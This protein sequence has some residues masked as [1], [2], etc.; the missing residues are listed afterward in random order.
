MKRYL[1]LLAACL[2]AYWTALSNPFL[3]DDISCIVQNRFIQDIRNLW[4][5]LNPMNFIHAL[6]IEN[7]G[8]PFLVASTLIDHWIW[9]ENPWGYRLD[10]LLLHALNSF[11]IFRVSLKL[12]PDARF[13]WLAALLFA[14]HPIHSEN[15]SVIAFRADILACLFLLLG[16][17]SFLR[18]RESDDLSRSRAWL[19]ACA[20]FFAFSLFSKESGIV[21]PVLLLTYEL[22]YPK[23]DERRTIPWRYFILISVSMLYYFGFREARSTYNL[24]S[25]SA[26]MAS[27]HVAVIALEDKAASFPPSP[28][29]WKGLSSKPV[30]NFMTMSKIFGEYIGLLLVPYPLQVDYSPD[31]ITSL[32]NRGL[33][34]SWLAWLALAVCAYYFRRRN[35]WITFALLWFAVSLAP[36]S[37]LK[38]LYNLKA[39]RYLYIPSVGFCWLFAGLLASWSMKVGNRLANAAC[40]A[41]LVLYASLC[42]A[43]G[44]D[45]ASES[46]LFETALKSQPG[47]PRIH[48]N[49]GTLYHSR[50]MVPEAEA[51]YRKALELNP[52][53]YESL[54]NLGLLSE[55]AKKEADAVR[56]YKEAVALQPRVQVPYNNLA[57]LLAGQGKLQEAIGLYVQS[58]SVSPDQPETRY[59]LSELYDRTGRP[60]EALRELQADVS[61]PSQKMSSLINMGVIYKENGDLEKAEELFK[62][63]AAL[64]PRS[65]DAAYNL[66]TAYDK[67]GKSK[68]AIA[69][70]T[71]AAALAPSG[72]TRADYNL[73]VLYQ[74]A[75]ELK[76]AERSYRRVLEN[77]PKHL[78][79]LNNL[80]G[81][82]EGRGKLEDA[83]ELF[84]KA[85]EVD[86]TKPGIR[87][88]LGNI[89]LKQNRLDE[90]V[91]QYQLA[92]DYSKLYNDPVEYTAP[93][94]TNLGLCYQRLGRAD[95]AVKEWDLARQADPHYAPAIQALNRLKQ[96]R[97]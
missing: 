43:R 33:W 9:K 65:F 39:E 26:I 62:Q 74:Q 14:L 93:I 10:S 63:A 68:E 30:H 81:L 1:L 78:Q 25:P 16:F 35:P 32:K 34:A 19:S 92:L 38:P 3:W 23:P 60:K 90:A 77:D 36:V 80:G 24:E 69:T 2:A 41:I 37:N 94:H 66:A 57:D 76:K 82:L 75:G 48:Y 53:S 11:L 85:A 95:D 96:G 40:A 67:G 71:K 29:P 49:L 84:Q 91:K 87:T 13:A 86:G 4:V 88:N 61:R 52:N 17:M 20:I 12:R 47:N 42:L 27:R 50:G 15:I 7:S 18:Y 79:A 58:L 31:L 22:L 70:F 45:W 83:W 6:P 28:P 54:T 46:A 97:Q 21:L 89:L 8:R 51:H 64:D 55:L 5:L 59:K 56:Y 44:K 73:A 72:D